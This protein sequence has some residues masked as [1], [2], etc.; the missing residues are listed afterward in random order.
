[1]VAFQLAVEDLP[2]RRGHFRDTPLHLTIQGQAA[3]LVEAIVRQDPAVRSVMNVGVRYAYVDALLADKFPA[4]EFVGVDFMPNLRELNADFNQPNLR[5]VTGYALELLEQDKLC[6]DVAVMVDTALTINN[7]ELRHYFRL[8]AAR[9]RYVVIDDPL[10]RSPSGGVEDPLSLPVDR[11]L[12][13][14]TPPVKITPLPG[15]LCYRHNYKAM[16][17]EAGFTVIHYRVFRLGH[18][19]LNLV[20]VVGRR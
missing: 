1:M 19:D 10:H 11:S 12:P 17:E 18:Y 7:R 8:L 9:A 6:A 14:Y 3:P 4:V 15:P 20:T 13:V 5:F 16:L 2:F